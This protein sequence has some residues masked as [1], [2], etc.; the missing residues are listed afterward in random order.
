[1]TDAGVGGLRWNG[2]P[3]I[4]VLLFGVASIGVGVLT[5][6]WPGQT[7]LVLSV[8]LGVYLVVFGIFWMVA[9]FAADAGHGLLV[10]FAGL[11][12]VLGGVLVLAQP[13]RGGALVVLIIGAYWVVWGVAQLVTSIFGHNVEHRGWHLV[14]SLF[15][16]AAGIVTLAWPQITALVIAWVA[17][18]W[19]ILV[20]A[21]D[22]GRSFE[23]R[24]MEQAPT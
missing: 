4:V 23:I 22:I 10:V 13:I 21:I 24:R 11:M 2:W 16:I 5:I 3:W 20:G 1:M 9:G 14:G 8:I 17:G 6:V 19:L 7:F 12:G 18:I 15:S